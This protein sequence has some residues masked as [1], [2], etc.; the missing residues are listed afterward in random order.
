MFA[1]YWRDVSGGTGQ[2]I[3][4]SILEPIFVSLMHS[5][6]VEYDKKGIVHERQGNRSK[7]VAPR[8][9]YKTKDNQWVSLS[10]SSENIAKRV[11]KIVGGEELVEDPR[12]KTMDDRIE[13]VEELDSIIQ[14][15]MANHTRAEVIQIF[16]ENEAAIAPIY[17]IEDIMKDP[18]FEERETIIDINDEELGEFATHGIVPKMSETPGKVNH[19]GPD[20]GEDTL[21]IL[22]EYASIDPDKIKQLADQGILA[23]QK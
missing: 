16:E 2:Y 3:D 14:K 19:A 10:T 18:Y 15:W 11:L 8:N 4:T 20:L 12:F 13:H 21:N 7:R 23:M 1:L 5:Q 17:N 22:I 9:T 6:I